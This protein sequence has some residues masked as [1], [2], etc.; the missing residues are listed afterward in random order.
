MVSSTLFGSGAPCERLRD[1]TL[2]TGVAPRSVTIRLDIGDLPEA[3]TS[4]RDVERLGDDLR[5]ALEDA[6]RTVPRVD[7]WIGPIRASLPADC[8]D[9]EQRLEIDRSPVPV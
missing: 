8:P 7:T 1:D 4:E 6:G 3:T 5:F 2:T 9:C